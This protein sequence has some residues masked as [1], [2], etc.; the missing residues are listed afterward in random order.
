MAVNVIT[1]H[2]CGRGANSES[3]TESLCEHTTHLIEETS[4]AM[5]SDVNEEILQGTYYYFSR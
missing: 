4:I 2:N 3:D 5:V 1:V